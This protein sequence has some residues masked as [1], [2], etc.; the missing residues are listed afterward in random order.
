MIYEKYNYFHPILFHFISSLSYAQ[1]KHGL[2]DQQGRHII[3]RGFVVCTND[4]GEKC[5]F[6]AMTILEWYVWVPILKLSD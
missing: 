4:S 1:I 5:F 2:R 3:P 6:K